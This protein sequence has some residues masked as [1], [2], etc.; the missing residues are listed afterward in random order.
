MS[1]VDPR[2]IHLYNN[3]IHSALPR[4]EFISRLVKITG[5]AAAAAQLARNRTVQFFDTYLKA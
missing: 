5:S 3:Y 1:K 2:V 4:R